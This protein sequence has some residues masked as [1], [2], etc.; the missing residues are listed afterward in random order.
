MEVWKQ[1]EGYEGIYEISNLGNV[2]SLSR[3]VNNH[4]GFKKQL[5][6]KILKNHISKTGYFVTDLKN[7]NERKTFKIHRLI[8]FAFIDKVIGKEYV[9]HI[10]GN[11]LNNNID[12]LEWCTIQ[13]NNKHAEKLGLKN[14]SGINNSKSKLK[15]EDVFFIRNSNLKLKELSNIY[16]LNESTISKI[17]LRKTY[18]KDYHV[19]K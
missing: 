15:I 4:S 6:E 14:D 9:N 2:K 5:K 17:I 1:I 10:D 12:N 13:E 11:K 3:L 7:N 19:R 8:A 16:N 18:K